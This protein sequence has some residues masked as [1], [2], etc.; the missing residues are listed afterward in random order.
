[1]QR[2]AER[3]SD[4]YQVR[5]KVQ[6][7]QKQQLFE[8]DENDPMILDSDDAEGNQHK[9][10]AVSQSKG[11]GKMEDDYL[12]GLS[13]LEKQAQQVEGET[14]KEIERVHGKKSRSARTVPIESEKKKGKRSP[15]ASKKQKTKSRET[16]REYQESPQ[17]P[18]FPQFTK[19]SEGGE[20]II[21][22]DVIDEQFDGELGLQT[23]KSQKSSRS[24][25]TE[26]EG[27]DEQQMKTLKLKKRRRE[28]GRTKSRKG[29]EV[30][31]GGLHLKEDT[32]EVRRGDKKRTRTK[33]KTKRKTK[34]AGREASR[35][36]S[37]HADALLFADPSLQP[38]EDRR[39]STK[40][41]KKARPKSQYL[42]II[43][44]DKKRPKSIFQ[45]SQKFLRIKIEEK[46]I[47]R[48]LSEGEHTD[49]EI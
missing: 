20:G 39:I 29:N 17:L 35:K 13:E 48:A 30:Q 12:E 11:G 43:T 3:S 31:N 28:T 47:E 41:E 16:D 38:L 1:M 27:E 33:R 15:K 9:K 34:K 8:V 25:R 7:S 5:I 37:K 44:S 4:E 22:A 6:Q 49:L 45:P 32:E 26:G 18:S 24:R 23:P 46:I 19:S 2:R 42:E 14:V 36:K 40:K 21:I 10:K